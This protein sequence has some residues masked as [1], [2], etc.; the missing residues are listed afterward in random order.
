[1]T[2]PD[3]SSALDYGSV[4]PGTYRKLPVVIEAITRSCCI[5]FRPWLT[6]RLSG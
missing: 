5:R 3:R 2:S 1:M 4:T 6:T